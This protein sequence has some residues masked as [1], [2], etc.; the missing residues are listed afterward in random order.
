MN[1]QIREL[2]NHILVL[3]TAKNDRGQKVYDVDPRYKRAVFAKQV[4]LAEMKE[5]DAKT[6]RVSPEDQAN[7]AAYAA[8]QERQHAA[9]V[10]LNDNQVPLEQQLKARAT[11]RGESQPTPVAPAAQSVG[12]GAIFSKAG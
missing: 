11:L 1:E 2:E 5:T 9:R 4:E 3:M 12:R 7:N 10:L 8:Y 6:V